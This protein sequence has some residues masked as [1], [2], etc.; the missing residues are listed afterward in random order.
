[1][2]PLKSIHHQQLDLLNAEAAASC[3]LRK[4]LNLHPVLEDSIQRLFNAMQPGTYVRPHRHARPDGWELMLVV[5]GAFSILIFEEDG[6]VRE[7]VDLAPA[8]DHLAVEIPAYTWHTVV[9]TARDT[10]MFEVKPGPYTP[11]TDKDFAPWA[12]AE[13]EPGLE[14]WLRWYEIAQP[15]CGFPAGMEK[16]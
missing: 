15:G 2:S 12:P 14:R 5:R 3:R 6:R 11:V 13:G 9:V 8:S 7:R 16:T 10:V 1:M 4:N